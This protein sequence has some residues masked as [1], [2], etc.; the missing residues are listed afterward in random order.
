MSLAKSKYF[1]CLSVESKQRYLHKISQIN[2]LD[3]YSLVQSDLVFSVDFY[4]KIGYP[5]IVSYLMFAPSPISANELKCYKSLESYN[6]FLSGWVKEIGLKLFDEKCLVIGK[7]YHS[8]KHKETAASTWI[9]SEMDGKVIYAHC[10]C[11]AGLGEACSHIGAVLFYID[12]AVRIRDSKTVTEK[13]AYW[14]LPSSIKDIPYAEC[15]DIDFTSPNTLKRKFD[16]E[17]LNESTCSGFLNDKKSDALSSSYNCTPPTQNELDA[18]F[19]DL[20]LCKSKPA[21]LSIIS[22]Y[23]VDYQPS[24]L[25]LQFPKMLGELYDSSALSLSYLDLCK[26]CETLSLSV[27]EVEQFN[28]EKATREQV[29]SKKWF[30]FRAGRITASNMYSVLHT[31]EAMPALS[32]IKKICYPE[33]YKVSSCQTKWG[34]DNEKIALAKYF[35]I[36]KHHHVNFKI[37][38]CGFF[39]S[40][41]YPFIGASLDALISC[42]CCGEGCVEI[43]NPANHKDNFILEAIGKDKTFCIQIMNTEKKLKQTHPYYFQIQTQ[44]HTCKKKFCDFFV[45]TSKDY[46]L[47][48]VY[49]D[50]SIWT[51]CVTKCQQVFSSS[52]L[53]ELVGK[54]FTRDTKNMD[55]DFIDDHSLYCYC[56]GNENGELFPCAGKSC[57]IKLFHLVCLKLNNKPKKNWL[58]PDCH[59]KYI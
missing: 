44:L 35:D 11:M 3:P 54:F 2:N 8:Q 17:I 30:Y 27:S 34:I 49:P 10:N 42:E 22:P 56:N 57:K 40:T 37:I 15:I 25:K 7:V 1:T 13:K 33:S 32:L 26:Q 50:N 19:N 48:R 38:K 59:K 20:S 47:E 41:E 43:K 36:V 53:P 6:F 51:A 52:I 28:V 45:N 18:F 46:H 21:I 5:D 31:L 39:I 4:P 29:F 14:M 16:E 9:I 55:F 12:A 23:S 24:S 58:C